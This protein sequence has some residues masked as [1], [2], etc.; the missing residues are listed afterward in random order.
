[1]SLNLSLMRFDR[2]VLTSLAIETRSEVSEETAST[3]NQNADDERVEVH[4]NHSA[5]HHVKL[6]RFWIQMTVELKW[7]D[8][9]KSRFRRI[10]F[11][12]DGFFSLPEG[13]EQEKVQQYVPILCLTSLYGVGRGIIAQ[14]TGSCE[15]GAY[16]LPLVDMNKALASEPDPSLN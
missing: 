12:L 6:P 8:G 1:M 4:I 15:G 2:C 5:R 9:E 13:L 3:P 11:G 7:P 16:F 10:A 14:A